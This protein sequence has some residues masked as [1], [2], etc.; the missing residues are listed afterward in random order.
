MD[1]LSNTLVVVRCVTGSKNV[2]QRMAPKW[3]RDLMKTVYHK[4]RNDGAK[5]LLLSLWVKLSRAGNITK[6]G[7][8]H[9]CVVH[10]SFSPLS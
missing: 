9:E 10:F 4:M 7:G 1:T 8:G 5:L 6:D 2:N 3:T